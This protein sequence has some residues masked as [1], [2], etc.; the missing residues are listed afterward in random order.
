MLQMLD[1]D[2]V[3][4]EV[5]GSMYF[6]IKELLQKGAKD[7]SKGCFFWK[8]LYGA[9]VNNSMVSGLFDGMSYSAVMNENN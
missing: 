8:N 4:S 5:V 3:K 1:D 6:S 7:D 9:P 2:G